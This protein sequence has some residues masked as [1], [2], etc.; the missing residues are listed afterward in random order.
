MTG[1]KQ[2]GGGQR[3]PPKCT[4]E[5]DGPDWLYQS[6]VS[7]ALAFRRKLWASSASVPMF[8][9]EVRAST[10]WASTIPPMAL[11]EVTR[12]ASVT[13]TIILSMWTSPLPA[14]A[15]TAA[16]CMAREVT[17]SCFGRMSRLYRWYRAATAA[18]R[19]K[20]LAQRGLNGFCQ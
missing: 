9:F 13:A 18:E 11:D 14:A 1:P 7:G 20:Y 12:T 19:P 8:A 6:K 4:E 3:P 15:S 2:R 10:A 16:I 5:F 17:H